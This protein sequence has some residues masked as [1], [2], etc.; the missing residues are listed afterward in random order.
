VQKL[1]KEQLEEARQIGQLLDLGAHGR[2]SM[3][4]DVVLS[5]IAG[6]VSMNRIAWRTTHEPK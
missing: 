1:L 2:S 3:D 4:G 5:V 6:A